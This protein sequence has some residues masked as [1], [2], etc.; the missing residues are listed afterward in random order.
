MKTRKLQRQFNLGR[1]FTKMQINK[2]SINIAFNR[3]LKNEAVKSSVCFFIYV[4]LLRAYSTICAKNIYF[5]ESFLVGK[6]LQKCT[7]LHLKLIYPV[8]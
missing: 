3:I 6:G 4:H 2:K 5:D 1:C 7:H 8:K